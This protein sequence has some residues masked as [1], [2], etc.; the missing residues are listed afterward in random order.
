MP[1]VLLL[2]DNKSTASLLIKKIKSE[3]GFDVSLAHNIAEA[4]TLLNVAETD[5]LAVILDINLPEAL[6]SKIIDFAISRNI[7]PIIF[8][9]EFSDDLRDTIW[10]KGIVDYV[11]KESAHNLDYII[12]ILN[13]I[14]RNKDIKVLVVDESKQSRKYLSALLKVHR[15]Q[16]FEAYDGKDALKI[17]GDNPSI[18]IAITDN[19]ILGMSGVEL[20]K[21][22]RQ[23]Y[24]KDMMSIIGL[25]ERGNNILSVNFIKNGANDFIN[26]PFLV[27]EFYSRVSQNI[28]M[29]ENIERIKDL[30]H[31]D[32]VT[33]LYNRRY[34]FDT[35]KMLHA[36][37]RRDNIKVTV[38]MI[39]IDNF[40]NVNDMYGHATGD[41]VLKQIAHII[42][43]KFRGSDV[44]SRFGG[45][46]FGV[47]ATNV[48]ITFVHEVFDSLRSFID[49]NDFNIDGK[50]IHIT[51]SIGVCSELLDSLDE[52][53]DKA[54]V[55]LSQAKH[56]GQNQIMLG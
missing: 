17:I 2:E 6:K 46:V 28:E 27:E 39:E 29:I 5:F 19:N 7:P 40:S 45:E 3:L 8:T 41:E 48:K 26:K 16:V 25:S 35:G 15:F 23:R 47:L 20:T 34:F 56:A 10:S 13:R 31:T 43:E 37:F 30:A 51:V 4:V 22:I 32:Y 33:G 18:K 49:N 55:M 21:R 12:S 54:G 11:L 42:E 52:M 53:I 36:N 9:N 24:S 14:N 38:A 1:Q 50:K 44:V